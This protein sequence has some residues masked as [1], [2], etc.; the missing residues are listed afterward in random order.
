MSIESTP[1]NGEKMVVMI[2]RRTDDHSRTG[3]TYRA[4]EMVTKTYE[5]DGR[6]VHLAYPLYLGA[7]DCDDLEQIVK[8]CHRSKTV[9]FVYETGY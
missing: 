9:E 5:S 6:T 8:A 7:E 4:Y 1:H 3:Y 2:E